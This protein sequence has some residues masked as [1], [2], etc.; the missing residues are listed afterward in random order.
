MQKT[1]NVLMLMIAIIALAAIA[2]ADSGIK[3]SWLAQ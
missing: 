1:A 3:N 2:Q